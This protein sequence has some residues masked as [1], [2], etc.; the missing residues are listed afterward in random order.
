MI[1]NHLTGSTYIW[2][3]ASNC[4]DNAT[5]KGFHASFSAVHSSKGRPHARKHLR[6]RA[7]LCEARRLYGETSSD[8]IERIGKY[9]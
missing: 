3:H 1:R 9:H 5:V 8:D 6:L 7:Q 2:R 4:R